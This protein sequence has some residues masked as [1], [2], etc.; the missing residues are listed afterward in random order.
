MG[1]KVRVDAEAIGKCHEELMLFLDVR[2]DGYSGSG[3]HL[4]GLHRG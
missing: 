2:V 3:V 1:G 4:N